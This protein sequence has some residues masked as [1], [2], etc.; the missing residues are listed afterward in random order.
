M[1]I[2]ALYLSSIIAASAPQATVSNADL[3][4]KITQMEEQNRRLQGRIEELEHKLTKLD[5]K[6]PEQTKAAAKTEVKIIEAKPSTKPEVKI[7]DVVPEQENLPRNPKLSDAPND[8]FEAAFSLMSEGNIPQ[9]RKSFTTFAKKYPNSSL[10]GEAYYWLGEMAFDEKDYNNAAINYLKGYR[11]Y[12]KG[13]KAPENIFKLAQT[14]KKL[15][16]TDE[17]C[18]NLGRFSTE[19]KDAHTNLRNQ[20]EDYASELRCK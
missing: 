17:A 2:L 7:Q 12:P 15:G 6:K 13:S 11:D 1:S 10:S 18:K 5:E 8:D 14:L 4:S 16:R 20:A 9:A 3:Y 19:F